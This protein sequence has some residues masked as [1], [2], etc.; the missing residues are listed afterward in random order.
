MVGGKKAVRSRNLRGHHALRGSGKNINF[1]SVKQMFDWK[2]NNTNSFSLRPSVWALLKYVNTFTSNPIRCPYAAAVNVCEG[3]VIQGARDMR[4][5]CSSSVSLCVGLKTLLQWDLGHFQGN[6]MHQWKWDA[7][8]SL[9]W[10]LFHADDTLWVPGG[11][12][13]VDKYE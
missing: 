2:N 5:A 8:L 6:K 9:K 11:A 1:I 4:Q 10:I 12:Q 13:A 7:T 3:C